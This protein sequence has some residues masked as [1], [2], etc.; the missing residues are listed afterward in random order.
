MFSLS[1]R[2]W[3]LLLALGQVGQAEN[4]TPPP[5]PGPDLSAH[6]VVVFNRADPDSQSLADTYAKARSIPPDRI[7]GLDCPSTEEIT[8]AEFETKIRQ[9]LDEIFVARGWLKRTETILPN[10]ILGL[11]DNLPVQQAQ[12]NPIWIMVLMRGIP[13]KIGRAHV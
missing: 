8:R 4:L 11:P 5:S 12:E 10:P 13:L 3:I 2:F 7:L 9:P 1:P 6:T